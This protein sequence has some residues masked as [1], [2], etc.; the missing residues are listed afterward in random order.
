MVQYIIVQAGG[1]GSRMEA[2]T[3]NKPKALVS[4]ENLP[5][6][7]HLFHKFPDKKF[8][9]IG[10]YKYDV[11]EKY[12]RTFAQVDYQMVCAEG[13]TGTCAG[14]SDALSYIPE[15][16]SFLLI[17]C[18]LILPADFH[19]SI[20]KQ[21]MIGLSKDFPCRWKYENNRF[22]E[23]CSSDYGVAGYFVFLD[24]HWLE[25]VPS[26]GEFVRWL[27][28]KE[29]IFEE[30]PLYHTREYGMYREWD[31]LPKSRCR[32]FNQIR[33]E[34]DRVYKFPLDEQGRELARRE[35]IWYQKLKDKCPDNIPKIY[36]WTPL[37]M[38]RID[39]K[40][41]YEYRDISFERK[42]EILKKMVDCLENIHNLDSVYA[43]K[44]SY[45]MAYLDKTYERLDKVR[46]LIPFANDR[47]VMVNGRKC[48]NVFYYKEDIEEMV[49]KY[50]P[51]K[52]TIIHGDCTF[53]NS[54]LKKNDIPV[55]ID[56][57]GYFGK[58]EIYGDPAYD[59]TKLYYSLVSNYD[60]F[61]LKNFNLTI[62]ES[63][64]ELIIASS[65]WEALEEYF[66][67]LL[68]E[69][70]ERVQIKLFLAMIWL[71]LT[72]YAWDD[73][74]SICGA[75]YNGLYYLEEVL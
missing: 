31:K 5:M 51:E 23:E 6:I 57:R 22:T 60:Q 32:P 39:G 48:R 4:I 20:A 26:A 67:E 52:F 47:T 8:I 55:L 68:G 21:N 74:D 72:T 54:L 34:D 46:D 71:S 33:M 73:Y 30:Q 14:I 18:D 36:Q 29:Y 49:M 2:L 53:S 69:K 13:H 17:W 15:K 59:W 62:H 65:S 27:Q 64:V 66:F 63:K 45:R 24:K 28:A 42:K 41:I 16:E 58:C 38:E 43:D 11:L 40:N 12:L 1:R 19:I 25:E 9:I 56:P 50:L 3:A 37:C 44:E 70:V 7:F 61:N 10:D 75:F 35:C